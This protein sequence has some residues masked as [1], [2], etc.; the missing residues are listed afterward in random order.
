MPQ[1]GSSGLQDARGRDIVDA[2]KHA[3]FMVVLVQ[4]EREDASVQGRS[5]KMNQCREA[6]GEEVVEEDT[7]LLIVIWDAGHL[8][9]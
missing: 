7:C 2:L 8:A 1:L 5:R 4:E 9:R 3:G 6:K